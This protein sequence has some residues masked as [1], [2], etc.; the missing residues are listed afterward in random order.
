[1]KK[2]K[3]YF[4]E[5]DAGEDITS[6][7]RYQMRKFDIENSYEFKREAKI[8]NIKRVIK[9]WLKDG[10]ISKDDLKSIVNKMLEEKK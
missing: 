8:E 6:D 4:S 9:D 5:G 10:D 3:E 2:F 7:Y 1:M